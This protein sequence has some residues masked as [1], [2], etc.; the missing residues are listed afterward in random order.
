VITGIEEAVRSF[1]LLVVVLDVALRDAATA[2]P[3]QEVGPEVALRDSIRVSE[4]K[5]GL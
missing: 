5:A 4:I 1:A 3:R 2:T